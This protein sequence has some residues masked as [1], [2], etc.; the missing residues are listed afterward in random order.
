MVSYVE[1]NP[2]PGQGFRILGIETV[3]NLVDLCDRDEVLP[4]ELLSHYGVDPEVLLPDEY[5]LL[6]QACRASERGEVAH[7]GISSRDLLWRIA[8]EYQ[9][10][11][12][13]ARLVGGRE[14]IRRLQL[15]VAHLLDGLLLMAD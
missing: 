14:S 4:W 12:E 1:D 3:R 5:T 2:W 13:V 11:G 8:D 6:E 7:I 10:D 9:V 15:A